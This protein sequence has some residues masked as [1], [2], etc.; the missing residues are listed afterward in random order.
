MAL[1]MGQVLPGFGTDPAGNPTGK[2]ATILIL[3]PVWDNDPEIGW[4]R[5]FYAFGS[6]FGDAN[7]RVA[8]HNSNNGGGWRVESL[9]V[10]SAE[11]VARID[12]WAGDDKISICR[13]PASATDTADSIPVGYR[14]E[15]V[16]KAQ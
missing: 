6:D 5:V 4:G 1:T 2:N 11:S 8:I 9:V 15:A 16:L 7:L 10:R 3:P 12:A 14:V 13:V